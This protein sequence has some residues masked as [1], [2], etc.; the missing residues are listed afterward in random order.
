MEL[1]ERHLIGHI[2]TVVLKHFFYIIY[3]PAKASCKPYYFTQQP[4]AKTVCF[5]ST[6][7]K[8][9]GKDYSID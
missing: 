3:A 9:G 2:L 5:S 6:K 1:T 7:L 8:N 4:M